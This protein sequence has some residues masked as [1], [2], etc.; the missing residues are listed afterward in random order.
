MCGALPRRFRIVTSEHITTGSLRRGPRSSVFISYAHE[1]LMVAR[2]VQGELTGL[3]RSN[4][5]RP[6]IR[7]I[8]DESH[9]APGADLPERVHRLLASADWLVVV[10]SR[11]SAASVW[12]RDEVRHWIHV[13]GREERLLIVNVE[14]DLTY[15]PLDGLSAPWLPHEVA[16]DLSPLP[17]CEDLPPAALAAEATVHRV[18]V[19]LAAA[20]RGVSPEAI[21]SEERSLRRRRTRLAFGVA[22]V[23]GVLA[24]L[25]LL[26]GVAALRSRDEARASDHANLAAFLGSQAL[27]ELPDRPDLAADLAAASWQADPSHETWRRLLGISDDLPADLT[28]IR[29]PLASV[30]TGSATYSPDG[31][32]VAVVGDQTDGA[33][34]SVLVV[35]T[36]HDSSAETR[37]ISRGRNIRDAIWLKSDR[38]VVLLERPNGPQEQVQVISAQGDA[39]GPAVAVP[40]GAYGL[41]AAGPHQFLMVSGDEQVEVD[42]F[43]VSEGNRIRLQRTIA[44]PGYYADGY[45]LGLRADPEVGRYWAAGRTVLSGRLDGGPATEWVP[46]AGSLGLPARVGRPWNIDNDTLIVGSYGTEEGTQRGGSLYWLRRQH[47]SV[48]IE[49][50]FSVGG[51]SLSGLCVTRD[52]GDPIGVATAAVGERIAL[53]YGHDFSQAYRLIDV[54][55]VACSD[56][57]VTSWVTADGLL[58]TVDGRMLG[59]Y[60]GAEW[61]SAPDHFYTT[62]ESPISAIRAPFAGADFDADQSPLA[63]TALDVGGSAARLVSG[64]TLVA[65]SIEDGGSTLSRLRPARLSM[66]SCL[67]VDVTMSQPTDG[68]FAVVGEEIRDG[69]FSGE[70][71]PDWEVRATDRDIGGDGERELELWHRGR[72]TPIGDITAALVDV[73]NGFLVIRRSWDRDERIYATDS[74]LTA[75][76]GSLP[77][78]DTALG[79]VMVSYDGGLV[80]ELVDIVDLQSNES[81]ADF[82]V[83]PVTPEALVSSMCGAYGTGILGTLDQDPLLRHV[84]QP[85]CDVGD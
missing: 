14:S 16:R 58:L 44:L 69:V 82:V 28:A 8:R 45:G 18:V 83:F 26:A 36:T 32:W 85:G 1:D 41:E 5:G 21:A 80:A 40:E 38:L 50:T 30:R 66:T 19:R 11:H 84:S 56:V 3:L 72:A 34:A 31:R 76:L 24:L 67:A 7:A 65:K 48:A 75:P 78:P 22:A 39:L 9:L 42:D 37:V 51:N 63:D 23:F 55:S 74:D 4:L 68:P 61:L 20:I 70:G 60:G 6:L 71:C 54:V 57:G 25:S 29:L 10:L 59:E 47:G 17:L 64:D 52:G 33:E 62:S 35:A 73:E 53:A 81:A 79:S 49:D 77:K 2:R 13:L 43:R 15:D 27:L 12:V 46:E